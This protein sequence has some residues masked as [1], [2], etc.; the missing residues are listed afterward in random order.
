MQ[1]ALAGGVVGLVVSIVG[2]VVT[3]NRGPAFGPHWYPLA[4]IVIA[5][6]CAW[7][8]GKLFG[9]QSHARSAL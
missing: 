8:G 9:A 3:W 1:H 4:L 6:P 2:T 5:M 7:V